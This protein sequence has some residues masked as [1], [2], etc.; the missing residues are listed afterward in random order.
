M[1]FTSIGIFT[2]ITTEIGKIESLARGKPECGLGSSNQ[3]T[4][5]YT[6]IVATH[7]VA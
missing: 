7:N 2:E 6:V 1:H 3:N 4:L 5:N